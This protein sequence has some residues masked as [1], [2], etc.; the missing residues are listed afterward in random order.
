MAPEACRARGSC[1]S[2]LVCHPNCRQGG[3][4]ERPCFVICKPCSLWLGGFHLSSQRGSGRPV[5]R[6]G[7]C[8]CL[9]WDAQRLLS[10]NATC[11]D[12]KVSPLSGGGCGGGCP[13]SHVPKSG[14][15]FHFPFPH[16][17]QREE[18]KQ[19]EAFEIRL[20]LRLLSD[21]LALSPAT[22]PWCTS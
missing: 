1:A 5:W 4:T 9:C 12:I 2:E 17:A 15:G 10:P 7:T 21:H 6:P 14:F 11:P 3:S 16:G 8:S 22:L 13:S 20:P 18:T 19:T